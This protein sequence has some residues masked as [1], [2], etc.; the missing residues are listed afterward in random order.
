MKYIIFQK[1]DVLTGKPHINES[2]PGFISPSKS[3]LYIISTYTSIPTFSHPKPSSI[4]YPAIPYYH[5]F[6]FTPT[7][8]LLPLSLLPPLPPGHN[9]LQVGSDGEGWAAG[10]PPPSPPPTPHTPL[11]GVGHLQG[12]TW[13]RLVPTPTNRW[14]RCLF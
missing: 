3:I 8:F 12:G 4:L 6:L 2:D 10:L 9:P 1:E 13:N 11:T 7:P 5:L 14:R